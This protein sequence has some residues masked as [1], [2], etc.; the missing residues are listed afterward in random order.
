ME[1][2]TT[3][4][5][6]ISAYDDKRWIAANRIDTL[7]FGHYSISNDITDDQLPEVEDDPTCSFIFSDSDTERG[8]GSKQDTLPAVHTVHSTPYAFIQTSDQAFNEL[9][10]TDETLLENELVVISN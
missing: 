2:V 3:N 4:K 9:L 1:T 10:M 5:L 7:P 6:S 8:E